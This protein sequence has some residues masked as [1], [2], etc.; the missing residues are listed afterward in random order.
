MRI[1]AVFIFLFLFRFAG[2]SQQDLQV[3]I[4]TGI[5]VKSILITPYSGIYKIYVDSLTIIN[6]GKN[7]VLLATCVKDSIELSYLNRKLGK[8]SRINFIPQDQISSLHLKCMDPEKSAV[9][10][11]DKIEISIE[12]GSLKFMNHV[13]LEDYIAGVVE[14]EVGI[15]ANLEY[16]KLQSIICRTYAL[17]HLRRHENEGYNLCNKVHCQAYKYKSRLSNEIIKGVKSTEGLVLVDSNLDLI[18]ASFHSNCGGETVNSEDVWSLSKSYLVSV[19]DTFCIRQPHAQWEKEIPRTNWTNYLNRYKV[20]SPVD[21]SLA[22]SYSQNS[23]EIFFKFS[24]VQI[25]LKTLRSDFGLN[26]TLFNIHLSGDSIIIKGKG[27]GH[28][29]GLC[30]EGAMKM[31]ELGHNFRSILNFYYKGIHLVPL[32]DLVFFR[33]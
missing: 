5:P 13:E 1:T 26:S 9:I 14:S 7:E 11:D 10:Y 24:E 6:L 33:G 21:I 15:T 3:R 17:S 20:S 28:G 25:P 19:K 32:A 18:T 22:C 12:T 16:Y 2:F 8:F 4:L 27:Y 29:V 23:R 30:Q 31:A